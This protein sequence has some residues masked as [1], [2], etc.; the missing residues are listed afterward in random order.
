M[1]AASIVLLLGA[2]WAV[3]MPGSPVRSWFRDSGPGES[4]ASAVPVGEPAGDSRVTVG[5]EMLDGG[6]LVLIDGAAPGSLIAVRIVDSE[7]VRL[8]VPAEAALES[9]PGRVRAV[10]DGLDTD[11]R[12]EIP[13]SAL[14]AELSVDGLVLL[15]KSASD[16]TYPG[17]QPVATDTGSIRF[18]VEGSP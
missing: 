6:V 5:Q 16:L 4:D 13:E 3:A 12:V 10:L 8:N 2:G 15:R 18:L 11:L 1:A 9:G 14:V 17:P 7:E